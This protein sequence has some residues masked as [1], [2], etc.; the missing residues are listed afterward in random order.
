M[1]GTEEKNVIRSWLFLRQPRRLEFKVLVSAL[2]LNYKTCEGSGER[3]NQILA[4]SSTTLAL[5][6]FRSR[7]FSISALRFEG[8]GSLAF[9]LF[10][11][12]H[13][14]SS[15]RRSQFF[16]ISALRLEGPGSSLTTSVFDIQFHIL[17]PVLSS[18]TS[19]FGHFGFTYSNHFNEL[20]WNDRS[21][22]A[23]Q[24]ASAVEFL[25]DNDIIRDLKNIKLADFGLSKKT[26][27]K[28]QVTYQKHL[29]YFGKFQVNADLFV[30]IDY[31]PSLMLFILNGKREKIVDGTPVKYACWNYEPNERLSM[32]EVV[33]TLKAIISSE[34]TIYNNLMKTK[35]I[36]FSSEKYE[37]N[38]ESRKDLWI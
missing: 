10:G 30:E 5:W 25:H 3:K 33:V 38:L 4:L 18:A 16:S 12:K 15:V 11:S 8:P 32:Q 23:L 19:A 13:F 28:H 27:S 26:L 7:F 34:I 2:R 29:F 37:T 35:K 1:K 20:N 21:N 24:L 36:S 14:G 9:R 31:G 17:V 6:N 22:L